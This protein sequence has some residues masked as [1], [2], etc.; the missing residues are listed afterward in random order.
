MTFRITQKIKGRNYVY[1]VT[2]YWDPVSKKSKQTRKYIGV[3]KDD[4]TIVTPYKTV[5]IKGVRD[6]G[7]IYLLEHL[8]KESKL[9]DVLQKVFPKEYANILNLIYFKIIKHAPY[10]LFQTW[11]ESAYLF[12][13]LP[14]ISQDLTDFTRELGGE[15]DLHKQFFVEWISQ[16]SNLETLIFDI[17]SISSHSKYNDWL[18]WGYNRDGDNLAQINLGAIVSQ[19]LGL[20][21]AYRFLPGSI[22]DVVTLKNTELFARDIGIKKVKFVL[23]KGFY[24]TKNIELLIANNLDFTIPLTFNTKESE[25]LIEQT[26]VE[27]TKATNSF[28]HR[29]DLMYYVQKS[30]TIGGHKLTAHVYL[31]T[32]RQKD[33]ISS[34]LLKLNKFEE[35]IANK[36]YSKEELELKLKDATYSKFYTIVKNKLLKNDAEISEH[37]IDMGKVILLT[38]HDVDGQELLNMYVNKDIV[39]KYFDTMK[40]ELNEK[41]L[42]VSSKDVFSGRLLITFLSLILRTHLER[43]SV[44]SKLHKTFTVHEILANLNLI[45]HVATTDGHHYLTEI[46]KNQ[47]FIFQKLG[48]LLPS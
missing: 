3:Q 16:H 7:A 8:A 29:H 44:K 4:G 41:R 27:L 15:E 47:R 21:L 1:D 37:I 18:E 39:E 30:A 17:T 35:E 31:N 10:Y 5:K 23:D 28:H 12:E 33:Q 43:L 20:P 24:S 9:K 13:G 6:Y 40:N 34:F 25:R 14:L 48:V 32:S 36:N 11:A 22:T 42:R 38:N 46:S 45:R 19:E 26:K 2:K